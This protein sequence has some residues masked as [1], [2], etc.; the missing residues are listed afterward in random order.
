MELKFLLCRGSAAWQRE[1]KVAACVRSR[2]AAGSFH[3]VVFWSSR[4]LQEHTRKFYDRQKWIIFLTDGW[5]ACLCLIAFAENVLHI[6]A[7]T[8]RLTIWQYSGK[9][10]WRCARSADD[11]TI[12]RVCVLSARPDSLTTA[13]RRLVAK[14]LRCL[15]MS[16]PWLF[17]FSLCMPANDERLSV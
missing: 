8:L 4:E 3:F 15:A 2:Q 17:S 5:L 9:E 13:L 16:L 14:F 1:T 12:T 10:N 7:R 11:L 6:P